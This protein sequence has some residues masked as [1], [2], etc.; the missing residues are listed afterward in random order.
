MSLGRGKRVIVSRLEGPHGRVFE[1]LRPEF[2]SKAKGI[3]EIEPDCAGY[4]VVKF[5]GLYMPLCVHLCQL[6]P[7]R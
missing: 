1:S 6:T 5:P 7:V 3:V 4:C 2:E